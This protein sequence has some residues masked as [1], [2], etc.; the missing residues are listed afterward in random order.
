M[1][2]EQLCEQYETKRTAAMAVAGEGAPAIPPILMVLLTII[3]MLLPLIKGGKFDP[4][5]LLDLIPQILAVIGVPA[6]LLELAKQ[7]I[8]ALLGIFE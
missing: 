2:V 6:E 3:P 5:V 7:I 8:S 1:T 4:K